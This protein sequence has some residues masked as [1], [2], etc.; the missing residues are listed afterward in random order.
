MPFSDTEVQTVHS[1]LKAALAEVNGKDLS[2]TYQVL[3]KLVSN[4]DQD[5]GKFAKNPNQYIADLGYSVPDG[6]HFH[7]RDEDGNEYPVE[8]AIPEQKLAARGMISVMHGQNT[9]STCYICGP[10]GGCIG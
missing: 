4:K 10:L 9:F 7:F 5:R 6:Y 1:E 8:K 2:W 3:E